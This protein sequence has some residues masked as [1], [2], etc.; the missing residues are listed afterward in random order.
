M[1]LGLYLQ[2]LFLK[3]VPLTPRLK[4]WVVSPAG[5]FTIFF[6][7]P[8]FK[9]GITFAN[10]ADMWIPPENL[11][12]PQQ[13]VIM[14]SGLIWCKYAFQIYPFSYNFL[15]VQGFMS[16]TGLYQLIRKARHHYLTKQ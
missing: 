6:W 16:L 14:I 12:T 2:Q 5:P 10:I 3:L 9:W 1:G 8:S 7:A 13:A 15:A 4:N 11:S